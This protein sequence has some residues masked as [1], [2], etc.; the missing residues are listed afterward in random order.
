MVYGVGWLV[1]DVE[2]GEVRV[3]KNMLVGGV[4]EV[5]GALGRCPCK[6]ESGPSCDGGGRG[7][8]GDGRHAQ[9][10]VHEALDQGDGMVGGGRCGGVTGDEV[11]DCCGVIWRDGNG[12]GSEAMEC[13]GVLQGDVQV[14]L[15]GDVQEVLQG[16]VQEVLRGDVLVALQGGEEVPLNDGQGSQGACD[17]QTFGH[18]CR[19]LP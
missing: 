16:D 11:D 15:Q 17:C 14:V 8:E 5:E 3:D 6:E 13:V 19:R 4:V 9:G 10:A 18:Q 2:C 1:C 7:V 12:E